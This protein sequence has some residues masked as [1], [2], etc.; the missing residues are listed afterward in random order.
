MASCLNALVSALLRLVLSKLGTD[1]GVPKK[2]IGEIMKAKELI[3]V[4]LDWAVAECESEATSH[5][6]F[7][8]NRTDGTVCVCVL[9]TNPLMSGRRFVMAP[10]TDWSQ[11]GP[12]VEREKIDVYHVR[13]A[14][15]SVTWYA[16]TNAGEHEYEGPTP[17]VAA[18]RCYV[19]SKN[20]AE[21][22]VP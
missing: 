18:M 10:S 13:N 17:L 5:D 19:A 14:D 8:R 4:T 11:G 1:V 9:P 12:I 15:L 16:S 20:G 21:V 3:G 7:L 22:D 6:I 2:P